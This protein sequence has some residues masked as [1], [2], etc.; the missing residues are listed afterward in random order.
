[1]VDQHREELPVFWESNVGLGAKR[2]DPQQER[3]GALK[4]QK[5]LGEHEVEGLAAQQ[6]ADCA[7]FPN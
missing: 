7:N 6:L 3:V 1:M 2:R 4:G 5:Q